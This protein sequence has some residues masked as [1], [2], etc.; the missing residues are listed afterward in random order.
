LVKIEESFSVY[1]GPKKEIDKYNKFENAYSK[2]A[3]AIQNTQ[4]NKKDVQ[5]RLPWTVTII[6]YIG[7][8]CRHSGGSK[9]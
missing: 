6:D 2:V 7:P 3:Q 1:R 8:G 5:G 9:D 4:I